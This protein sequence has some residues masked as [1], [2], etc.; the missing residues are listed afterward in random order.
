MLI[1]INKDDHYSNKILPK[2]KLNTIA[3]SV[4]FIGDFSYSISRTNQL[5]TNKLI[6]LSDSYHHH[7]HSV[8]LGW[9]WNNRVEK[10]EILYTVYR[11]SNRFIE[12]IC[13]I[14]PDIEYNFEVAVDKDKYLLWFDDTYIEV[15]RSSN[16]ILPRYVLFPF[17]GGDEPAP[18]DFQFELKFK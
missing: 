7:R 15:Y 16:W 6:G 5:D 1:R 8:R 3:G 14:E 18:K 4:K 17:F 12:S 2:I 9:R 10:I 13:Y 11:R